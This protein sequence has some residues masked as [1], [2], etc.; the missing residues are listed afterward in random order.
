M[1]SVTFQPSGHPTPSRQGLERSADVDPRLTR[2]HYFDNRLLSAEDLTRDQIYLDGRL[3]EVGRAL[4]YGVVRGLDL[5]LSEDDGRINITP[6][7]AVSAAGRVLELNRNLSLDLHDKSLITEL[8]NGLNRR[9]NRALYAVVL[10]YAEAGADVAEV[11]PTD[12]AAERRFHFDVIEEGVHFHLQALHLPLSQQ[13]PLAM[14]AHLIRQLHGDSSGAGSVPEDAVALGILAIAQDKPLWLDDQLL[15][16]P[17][18]TELAEGDAQ[19]DLSRRYEKLF[20]DVLDQRRSGGLG[21]DFAASDYFSLLPPA[22]AVPKEAID[23][24]NGRQGYFPE[25]FNVWTAP[26]RQAELALIIKESMSLPPID[27]NVDKDIDI[28]VLAPLGNQDYGQ[29]AGRLVRP[30]NASTGELG[31]LELLRLRLYRRR[32]VHE[33][34]TDADTWQSIWDRVDSESLMFIRRPLR[35]AESHISGILLNSGDAPPPLPGP[36]AA[37]VSPAD[38]DLLSDEDGS[39]LNRLNLNTLAAQR[40]PEG[41]DGEQALNTL[42]GDEMLAND[43]AMVQQAT[44]LAL[45]IERQ[46]D[47]LLWQSLQA[48][49]N[50]SLVS[51]FLSALQQAQS[52][53]ANTAAA[54]AAIGGDFGLAATLIDAWAAEA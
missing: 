17:M 36:D 32:V 26:V 20:D 35:A 11:F 42:L 29:L 34:D 12:L 43:A 49:S 16:Q 18:R 9:F 28:I 1:P 38:Y 15:R 53:A 3:R 27:L 24:V 52:E 40:P 44:L 5:S 46:Y 54:V 45:R 2:S 47:A 41:E 7:L 8:N 50:A 19:L 37:P 13:D 39:F 33:I 21:G 23:P 30:S 14:R 25:S 4:G 31:G 22:G 48:L 10:E 51:E 6:G